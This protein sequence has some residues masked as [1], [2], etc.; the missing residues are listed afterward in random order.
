[1]QNQHLCLYSAFFGHHNLIGAMDGITA[2]IGACIE[3]AFSL[4]ANIFTS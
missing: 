2:A 4:F 3:I 1:M